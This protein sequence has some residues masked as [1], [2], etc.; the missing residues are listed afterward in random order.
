MTLPTARTGPE[1]ARLRG[2]PQIEGRTPAPNE[3]NDA[4]HPRP[5][6]LGRKPG[7]VNQIEFISRRDKTNPTP[8]SGSA[9]E[10]KRTQL[11][12]DART[13]RTQHRDAKRTQIRGAKRT[14]TRIGAEAKRTQ[15]PARKKT[16]PGWRV[17]RDGDSVDR[18]EVPRRRAVAATPHWRSRVTS[19]GA[20]SC[21][22]SDASCDRPCGD[23]FHGGDWPY[24][25]LGGKRRKIA[26]EF[27]PRCRV[28]PGAGAGRIGGRPGK[29]PILPRSA[30]TLKGRPPG[31]SGWRRSPVGQPRRTGPVAQTSRGVE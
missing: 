4:G 19:C 3:P 20:G 18:F 15:T 5:P 9:R 28:C 29:A 1:F 16:A 23:P 17:T 10:T 6:S 12:D 31:S 30:P 2:S 25:L 24:A 27:G 8:A 13:K 26:G 21:C 11:G 7:P 14:Q 22:A